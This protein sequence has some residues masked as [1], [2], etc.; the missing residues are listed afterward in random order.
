[1]SAHEGAP[2]WTRPSRTPADTWLADALTRL[3]G[4]ALCLAGPAA[5]RSPLGLPLDPSVLVPSVV[6][7]G[8]PVDACDAPTDGTLVVLRPVGTGLFHAA[9]QHPR[10]LREDEF[11]RFML[12]GHLHELGAQRMLSLCLADEDGA[13]VLYRLVK[14]AWF[15]AVCTAVHLGARFMPTEGDALLAWA[16]ADAR[17]PLAE[18]DPCAVAFREQLD[19]LGF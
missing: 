1:M 5:P 15:L 19:Q 18:Q 7:L 8:R 2:R 3:N 11:T 10:C 17:L 6:E 16:D 9:L 4:C 14:R 12:H 13:S